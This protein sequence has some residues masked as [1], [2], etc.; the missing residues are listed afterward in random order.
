[1]WRKREKIAALIVALFC[2]AAYAQ[3]SQPT[4]RKVEPDYI[5]TKLWIKDLSCEEQKSRLLEAAPEIVAVT[6]PAKWTSPVLRCITLCTHQLPPMLGQIHRPLRFLDSRL[7]WWITLSVFER[8]DVAGADILFFQQTRALNGLR[9]PA[10][11][12]ENQSKG[13]TPWKRMRLIVPNA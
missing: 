12:K 13:D 4:A 5:E 9:N 6:I 7:T 2:S 1:M 10:T 8:P 3:N 11:R